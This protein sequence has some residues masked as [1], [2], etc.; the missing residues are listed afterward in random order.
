MEQ[1]TDI[2]VRLAPALR[3][4]SH[5]CMTRVSVPHTKG[6]GAQD[7][8]AAAAVVAP[9]PSCGTARLRTDEK[10]ED[11]ALVDMLENE[12]DGEID[13]ALGPTLSQ[14]ASIT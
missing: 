6:D 12:I 5:L 14:P 1:R 13:G 11:A 10:T 3:L 9:A 2:T 4:S 7:D 8:G